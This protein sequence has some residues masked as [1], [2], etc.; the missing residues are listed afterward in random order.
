VAI[1]LITVCIVYRT[2]TFPFIHQGFLHALFNVVALTPLLERFEAEHG[3]LTSLLLFFGRKQSRP[4][5]YVT[6]LTFSSSA[7]DDTCSH[8]Y[9]YREYGVPW[10]FCHIG[11]QVRI[12][13]IYSRE[14]LLTK[15][16]AYGSSCYLEWKQ[17]R[18]IEQIHTLN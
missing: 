14:I 6:N 18:H 1:R 10:K 13:T 15:H 4:S 8:I 16:S 17:S 5:P 9:F 7:V 3:T 11:G 12:R 2:N